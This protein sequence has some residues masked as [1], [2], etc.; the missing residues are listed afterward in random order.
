MRKVIGYLLIIFCL[1]PLGIPV[2][3][4]VTLKDNK[5]CEILLNDVCISPPCPL[6]LEKSEVLVPLRWFATTMGASSVKWDEATRTVTVVVDDFFKAHEYLSFLNGLQFAS[7]TYPL[8]TRLQ[9]LNLPAYPLYSKN[10][11][12][13]NKSPIGLD[14]VSGDLTMP[15]AVYDYKIKN[16]TLYVGIDWLNTLFLAQ[17]EETPTMLSITYPTS[18]VLTQD[19]SAL[20]T[21][22]TPLSADEALALWIHGEQHRNGALQY[23][24]LSLQL[25]EAA[26]THLHTQGWVTGGSSPS[27][28][29]VTIQST[30]SPD[31][32]TFIYEVVF[33]EINGITENSQIHQ[34]ITIKKHTINSQDY[35]FI[36]EVTGDLDYYSVLS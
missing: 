34:T 18:D 27:L 5:E 17:I 33:K 21:L 35:W 36:T 12:M 31:K 11:P 22:T 28:G 4:E 24:A 6:I 20:Q 7:D 8:P 15:W 19:I 23:T 29:E 32:D 3:G 9:N 13:L 25:K 10:P 30:T 26:L 14:I 2:Y 16:D 1:L